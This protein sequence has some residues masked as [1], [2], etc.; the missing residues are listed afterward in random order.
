MRAQLHEDGTYGF[1]PSPVDPGGYVALRAR[2]D[3]LVAVSAC[4]DD[5]PYNAG[6]A[7]ALSLE[8]WE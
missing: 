5:A 3:V 2:L 4:P 8:V 1:G 7:K 6:R